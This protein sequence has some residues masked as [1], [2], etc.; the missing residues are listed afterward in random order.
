MENWGLQPDNFEDGMQY[1]TLEAYL[2]PHTIANTLRMF[3]TCNWWENSFLDD[4]QTLPRI[5]QA[6]R[7]CRRAASAGALS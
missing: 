5:A 6:L 3:D 2:H 1:L 7:R 4:L